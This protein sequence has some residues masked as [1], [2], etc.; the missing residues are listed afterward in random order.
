MDSADFEW[1][2]LNL[3]HIARHGVDLDEAEAILDNNPLVLRTADD[4][5]LAYGQAEDGRYLLFVFVR[6]AH[7]FG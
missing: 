6:E 5:H 4:K 1:D 2:E 3:A 7:S